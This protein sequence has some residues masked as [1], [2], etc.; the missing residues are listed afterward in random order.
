M[1]QHEGRHSLQL[2]KLQKEAVVLAARSAARAHDIDRV[3]ESALDKLQSS[4][5]PHREALDALTLRG[6][7]LD[8][9]ARA[10]QE[11]GKT[12]RELISRKRF[13]QSQLLVRPL[14]CVGT[15]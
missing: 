1:C 9:L 2:V 7:N 3:L 11:G 13:L 10:A 4:A 12:C 8:A 15:M 6:G 14:C 5:T